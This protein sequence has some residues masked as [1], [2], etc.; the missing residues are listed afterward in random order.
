MM[1]GEHGP[2]PRQIAAGIG[3]RI[4]RRRSSLGMSQERLAS[5]L[6]V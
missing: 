6:G 1:G 4:Q 5:E 2:Q 3:S